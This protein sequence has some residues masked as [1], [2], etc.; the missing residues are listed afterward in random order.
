MV[1]TFEA[2]CRQYEPRLRRAL[3]AAYGPA[4]GVDACAE[5]MAYLWQHRERVLAMSN[6]AG[7]L[8]RVGQS[9]ARRLRRPGPAL[10]EPAPVPGVP[11]VEPRLVALLASLSESQRVCVVLVHAYGFT[12][13]E[14]ADILGV[15]HSTVRTH[16][17]RA[18]ARLR[19]DLEADRA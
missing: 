14:V 18:L 1:D 19:S 12:Q 7:Y 16:L 6:P 9:A 4:V 2:F 17:A 11:E 13:Q 5:A 3:A 8:Y 15:D 10:F